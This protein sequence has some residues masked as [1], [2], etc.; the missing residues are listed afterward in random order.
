MEAGVLTSPKRG[1]SSGTASDLHRLASQLS[2]RSR[3][4]TSGSAIQFS[5]NIAYPLEKGNPPHAKVLLHLGGLHYVKNYTD[6]SGV[7]VSIGSIGRIGGIAI[8]FMNA[9]SSSIRS[10]AASNSSL[11]KVADP[12]TLDWR[13]P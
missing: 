2:P 5:P 4:G 9:W 1:H 13:G 8:R 6:Y 3:S 10:S 12:S 7:V 11:A